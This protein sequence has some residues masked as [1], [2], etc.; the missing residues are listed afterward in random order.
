MFRYKIKEGP[1]ANFLNKYIDKFIE[2]VYTRS[3]TGNIMMVIK[4]SEGVFRSDDDNNSFLVYLIG[5]NFVGD[6]PSDINPSKWLNTSVSSRGYLT[7]VLNLSL[8]TLDSIEYIFN[9]SDKRN[10]VTLKY[11]TYSKEEWDT[12]NLLEDVSLEGQRI[13][14]T[15]SDIGIMPTQTGWIVPIL[16]MSSE[17]IAN[18]HIDVLTK[19]TIVCSEKEPGSKIR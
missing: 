12:V 11:L 15:A 10:P 2:V 8:C 16:S 7:Y 14:I 13:L 18:D 17:G 9:V 19:I 5:E 4:E 3:D 6:L 1:I